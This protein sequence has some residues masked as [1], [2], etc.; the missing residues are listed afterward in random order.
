MQKQ[1]IVAYNDD[2]TP[3]EA[4]IQFFVQIFDMSMEDAVTLTELI[5]TTDASE[6]VVLG[7]YIPE[8]AETLIDEC[9]Q[10]NI[11]NDLTFRIEVLQK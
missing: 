11:N 9:N 3:Y 6:P 8:I 4:V 1:T 5:N 10:A 7:E 2:V